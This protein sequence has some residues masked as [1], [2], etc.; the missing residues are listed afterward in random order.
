MTGGGDPSTNIF[1]DSICQNHL[2][3]DECTTVLRLHRR[4]LNDNV[5]GIGATYAGD[6]GEGT[7]TGD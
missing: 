3:E 5:V 2:K 7:T 6:L 4:S 1:V